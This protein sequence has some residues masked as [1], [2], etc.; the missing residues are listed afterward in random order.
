MLL[1]ALISLI[2]GGLAVQR[3]GDAR[4]NFQKVSQDEL[5]LLAATGQLTTTVLTTVMDVSRIA[6][7]APEDYDGEIDRISTKIN[8]LSSLLQQPEIQRLPNADQFQTSLENF[9]AAMR[10]IQADAYVFAVGYDRSRAHMT[11]AATDLRLIEEGLYSW[12][13]EALISLADANGDDPLN[14]SRLVKARISLSSAKSSIES[15]LSGSG[16]GDAGAL[17]SSLN[18]AFTDFFLTFSRLP[19]TQRRRGVAIE[20]AD[21][22]ERLFGPDGVPLIE[23][24]VELEDRLKTE[25]QAMLDS[26]TSLQNLATQAVSNQHRVLSERSSAYTLNVRNDRRALIIATAFAVGISMFIFLFGIERLIV[27]NLKTV[28]RQLARIQS[29]DLTRPE[30]VGGGGEISALSSAVDSLRESRIQRDALEQQLRTERDRAE[31]LASA[32]SQ[33]LSMMS[34][35]VRTPLNAIMGLFE[36]IERSDAPDR[37]KLRAKKGREAAK[38]LF[39]LL[40]K[41]LDAARME[42]KMVDLNISQV[43]TQQFA[44]D[45]HPVLEGTIQASG[46]PLEGTIGVAPDVPA[47]FYTDQPKLLQVVGNLVDNSVRFTQ[48]G[49]L[50]IHIGKG[51]DNQSP[52][53]EISVAD[54]GIGISDTDQALVFDRFQQVHSGPDRSFGGSGLGLNICKSIVNQMGGAI[55]LKSTVGSGTTFTVSLPIKQN[56]DIRDPQLEAK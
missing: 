34:H 15:L 49:S 13:N 24:L 7:L 19:N 46:K 11:L 22:R 55:R 48:T 9:T 10:A 8:E 52:T 36:L 29:S 5:P 47:Y 43:D 51:G 27:R 56:A 14:V 45:L 54:T 39:E 35:E 50:H 16:L 44:E 18:L 38:G 28:G 33:F 41:V 53:I 2:V 42:A 37:Q 17:S 40:S 25:A 32:K 20:V 1:I 30:L 26:L 12:Q 31:S 21:V 23:E 6:A 3:L 4:I